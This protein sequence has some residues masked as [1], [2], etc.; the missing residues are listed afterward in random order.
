MIINFSKN[1]NL[2]TLETL[3]SKFSGRVKEILLTHIDLYEEVN[4]ELYQSNY[5]SNGRMVTNNQLDKIKRLSRRQNK[6]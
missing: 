4:L 6:H 1:F 2:K 5:I 3:S